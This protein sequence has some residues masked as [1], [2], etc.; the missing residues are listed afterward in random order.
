MALAVLRSEGGELKSLFNTSGELYREMKMS[1]RL[2]GELDEVEALKLLSK[3]GKLIKRP[4][5]IAPKFVLVGFREEDWKQ[6][7]L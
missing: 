5:V 6:R 2:K 7:L 1:E 3:H 4:L